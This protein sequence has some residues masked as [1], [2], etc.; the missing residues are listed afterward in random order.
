MRVAVTGATGLIGT[1]IVRALQARGDEV[2]VLSRDAL[3]AREALGDVDAHAWTPVEGPAPAAALSGRDGVIHLAGENIA[4]RWTDAARRRIHD[5]RE[6]GTRNLVEGLRAADPR[7]R[8]LVSASGVNYY[9]P[10]G[11]EPVTEEAAPGD[12]FLAHLCIAWEREALAA[13]ELGL[14]V[15]TVRTAIVLDRRAG[16]LGKML[17]FFRLGVGGP[18]AGG[19]QYLPWIHP[20]DIV[21]LYLTALSSDSWSGAINAAAPDPPT[22]REFSRALGRAL[23]RPAIFPVPALAVRLLYG[24]MAEIVL[25]GQRI[26]PAR[27]LEHGYAFEHIELLPALREAL[28]AK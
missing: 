26:V 13:S 15:V 16:A 4:Q 24:D 21:G 23:R 25:V 28:S 20:D 10:R 11:D 8:V 19:H 6:L 14:R 2:T 5:T 7:P 1:R 18:V 17:P 27:A 12:D 3:R 22:N 9:G